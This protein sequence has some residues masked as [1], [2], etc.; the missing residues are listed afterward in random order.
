LK[1]FIDIYLRPNNEPPLLLNKLVELG[2]HSVGLNSKVKYSKIDIVHRIDLEPRNQNELSQ[3]LRKD[4]WAVEIMTV[5]CRTRSISRQAGKD[6][7]VDLVSFPVKE[8][9]KQNHLDRQQAGLMRDSGCGY[10]VDLSLLLLDDR[11]IFKKNVESLKRNIQNA[12][13]KGVPVIASS[14]ASGLWGLRDPYGL[15]S[16]LSLLDVDEDHA[17]EMISTNIKTMI[18]ENRRKLK[19]SHFVS[20]M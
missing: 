2:Y 1:K 5:M 6:R 14:G 18:D 15:A 12:V 9:R 10:L 20:V 16:L 11:Y 7:R 13:K 19:N 17:L 4:R 8:R 3:L